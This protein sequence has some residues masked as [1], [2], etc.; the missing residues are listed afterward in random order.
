MRYV[1]NCLYLLL[2]VACSPYLIYAALRYGKYRDGWEAKFLGRVPRRVGDRPCLWLHAVSVGEVNLLQPL[3]NQLGQEHPDWECVVSTTT[4]TGFALARKKYAGYQVFYCPLD[5]SWSVREAVRRIRPRLLVLVELELWPNLIRA[6]RA[7][8]TSVALV[9]GRL[10]DRS[11]RG[12]GRIRC[13]VRR[14]LAQLDLVA[15]QDEHYAQRFRA[16]GARSDT[17]HVTGSIKF[18]GA[19]IERDNPATQRLR[20]LWQIPADAFVFLAGSTQE[21]EEQMALSVF[22]DIAPQCP[23][24]RLILVPRHPE[25]FEDVAHLLDQSGVPW[26]R[27]SRLGE[28]AAAPQAARVLLVDVVGELGAWWGVADVGLVGG[29]FGPRG[30]QN[31]IEPAG[32]GVAVCFGPNTWNFRDVVT[33]L[34]DRHAAVV[35]RDQHELAAFVHRCLA[36]PDEARELGRRAQQLVLAQ[37]GATQRTVDLLAPL[38]TATRA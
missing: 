2:L 13:F 15:V 22:A 8:G 3:L 20:Q 16:L 21:P 38:V 1:L 27:R 31:M 9:N 35:V 14:L 7:Y 36:A 5:F 17:V 29:S 34:L 10:S 6:A 4:R 28:P 11:A 37:Q 33:Q 12:Y 19:Q 24:A 32:Y 25:R 23:A 30:G 18:D 26:Q